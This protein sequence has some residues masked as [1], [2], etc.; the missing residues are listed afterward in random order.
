MFRRN[1]HYKNNTGFMK[2]NKFVFPLLMLLILPGFTYVKTKPP[3]SYRAYGNFANFFESGNDLLTFFEFSKGNVVAEV[4]AGS[5]KNI[6][7][8][9]LLTDSITFYVQDID[10]TCLNEKNF[11]KV[12]RNCEKYK[13]P[14]T[15]VFKLCIGTEKSTLL[16][17]SAFDKIFLSASF[18]EFKFMDDMIADIAKKLKPHGKLYIL[19]S[20]CLEKTHKNYTADEVTAILQRHHFDLVKKDGK[21]MNGSRGLF[22]A[23]YAR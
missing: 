13:R 5:G 16:P 17:D 21:D 12:I 19:E 4:G 9:S 7:G 1:R 23:V 6:G 3:F 2:I 18:H 22:R 20:E 8:L 14:L 11:G 15:C 10:A